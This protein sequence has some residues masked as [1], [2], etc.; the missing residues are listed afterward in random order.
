MVATSSNA[1]WGFSR[2]AFS[3][4]KRFFLSQVFTYKTPGGFTLFLHDNKHPEVSTFPSTVRKEVSTF[5]SITDVK[6]KH[7]LVSIF[8]YDLRFFPFFPRQLH[9]ACSTLVIP[10]Q[11][12]GGSL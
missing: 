1:W 9:A 11:N 6:K 12:L 2:L 3:P 7:S 10:D 8:S 5:P 4:Q